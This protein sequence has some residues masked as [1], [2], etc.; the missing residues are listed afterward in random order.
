METSRQVLFLVGP[1][2]SGK[3]A[4]ALELARRAPVEVVNADSR[5]VYRGLSIGAA[6]PT[7]AEQ[8]IVRHHVID[9]A[10][11]DEPFSLAAFLELARAAIDDI[12]SRGKTPVVVGGSGQY[13]WALAEGWRPPTAP[14]NDALRRELEAVAEREGPDALHAR[15]RAIDPGAADAIDPRNVRRVARAIE[16]Y[17]ATGKPFSRQRRKTPPD[18]APVVLGLRPPSR[19][20]LHRRIDARVDA[21]LAQGWLDE[22]RALL[23]AGCSPALPSF[24]AAGYRE[25][26][27]H[28]AGE[29][30]LDDAIERAKYATHR[31]ARAQG[32]WF[33]PSDQRIAWHTNAGALI[34]TALK[35]PPPSMREGRGEG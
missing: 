7:A 11:P 22:V 1:T 32:A 4:A 27:A 29:L 30:S 9:V 16:V 23:D 35:L 26:A 17:E 5:Q 13:A 19:A 15:L 28:L 20:E 8:A 24:S 18:F 14:P 3:T 6:K 25:L 34:Q 10:A 12:G 21:M 31:L 2:A 33:R